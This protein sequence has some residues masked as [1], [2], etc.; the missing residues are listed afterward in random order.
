MKIFEKFSISFSLLLSVRPTK[1]ESILLV[2]VV[3]NST[4]VSQTQPEEEEGEQ[5]KELAVNF[6]G[7]NPTAGYFEDET[8]TT[9]RPR[10]D[11]RTRFCVSL[12]KTTLAVKRKI[13]FL[14]PRAVNLMSQV[15]IAVI[16]DLQNF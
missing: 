5:R 7:R 12:A 14:S 9:S 1:N 2:F 11:K 10:S 13:S 4:A 3:R 8:T 16:Q 15:E 6:Q